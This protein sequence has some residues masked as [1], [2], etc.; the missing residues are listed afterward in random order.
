M[1]NLRLW[2][3]TGISVVILGIVFFYSVPRT[4]DIP[5]ESLAFVIEAESPSVELKD[6]FKAGVHTITGSVEANNACASVSAEA[7]YEE[8]ET[9]DAHIRVAVTITPYEGV[10]LEL[11]TRMNIS[12]K[13][14]A[15]A[16]LPLIVSVNDLPAIV[17][18]L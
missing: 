7:F 6:V 2:L 11:P 3:A 10:C 4:S 5:T 9:E 8:K 1:N 17:I 14:S 15:P 16:K 13:V 18:E 12:T